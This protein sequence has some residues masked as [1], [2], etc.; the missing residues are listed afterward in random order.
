MRERWDCGDYP[1]M[2]L[3]ENGVDDAVPNAIRQR[4]R[5]S[6]RRYR[7][8]RGMT[9][10]ASYGRAFLCFLST[11][12]WLVVLAGRV[13]CIGR[14]SSSGRGFAGRGR[15][16]PMG[17]KGDGAKESRAIEPNQTIGPNQTIEPNQAIGPNQTIEPN[18]TKELVARYVSSAS[19]IPGI[20]GFVRDM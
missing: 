14:A 2:T 10:K 19:E 13:V 15:D 18:Q 1:S 4:T 5:E 16:G 6:S 9:I 12:V 11:F 8:F 7:D 20:D 3:S 17:T